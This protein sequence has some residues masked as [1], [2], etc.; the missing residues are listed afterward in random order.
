MKA[1]KEGIHQLESVN[2]EFVMKAIKEGIQ[3]NT[4]FFAS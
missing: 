3:P 4:Q 2:I 1:T